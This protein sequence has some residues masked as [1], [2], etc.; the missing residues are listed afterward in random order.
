[1]LSDFYFIFAL[2][3]ND[4]V[5]YISRWLLKHQMC[6]ITMKYSASVCVLLAI[7][8]GACAQVARYD[9]Y[10]VFRMIPRTDEQLALLREFE[11]SAIHVSRDKYLIYALF[12]HFHTNIYKKLFWKQV[13]LIQIL[14]P[15]THFFMLYYWL[16]HVV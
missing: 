4:N 11:E 14:L 9:N 13:F 1:M 6:R 16:R 10:K 5:R 8:A 15:S 3:N 2:I 7:L 12:L